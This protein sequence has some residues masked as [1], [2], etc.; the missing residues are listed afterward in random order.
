MILVEAFHAQGK[1]PSRNSVNTV[2]SKPNSKIE[3]VSAARVANPVYQ[4]KREDEDEIPTQEELMCW[5]VQRHVGALSH[6]SMPFV[7][8]WMATDIY[9]HLAR[10]FLDETTLEEFV[11]DHQYMQNLLMGD[12]D[13][14]QG[15]EKV[16]LPLFFNATP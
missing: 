11:K 16:S 15:V 9:G 7:P 2:I 3:R 1:S 14:W 4:M 10:T 6:M 8:Q 13:D 5:T 12:Y